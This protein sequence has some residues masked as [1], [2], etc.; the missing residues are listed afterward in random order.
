M[1]SA[2][3]HKCFLGCITGKKNWLEV[4]EHFYVQSMLQ[5]IVIPEWFA[6]GCLVEPG[7][8]TSSIGIDS[9]QRGNSNCYRLVRSF[10]FWGLICTW[11]L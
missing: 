1:N 5:L 7:S 2:L 9:N 4:S 6:N 8:Y 10:I 11:E 3:L